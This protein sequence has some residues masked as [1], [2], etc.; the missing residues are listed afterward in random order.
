MKNKISVSR[1]KNR[2]IVV[3]HNGKFHTKLNLDQNS[4]YKLSAYSKYIVI[5]LIVTTFMFITASVALDKYAEA[6]NATEV[7]VEKEKVVLVVDE[8]LPPIL[9]KIAKCES[10]NRQYGKDGKVLKGNVNKSDLGRWQINTDIW[11]KKATE[12]GYDLTTSQGNE[13]MARWLFA[14]KGS[15][16]WVL[17]SKCWNK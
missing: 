13:A 8:T 6:K 16:P 12:L 10:S 3:Y 9:E 17:S 15:V 4:S 2:T 7:V 14:N 11:G 5:P 1:S